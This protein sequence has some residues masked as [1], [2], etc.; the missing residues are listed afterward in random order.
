METQAKKL[1]KTMGW[2]AIA[3][4]GL[5]CTLPIIGT[6]VGVGT[7]TIL[8]AYFEKIAVVVLGISAIL[9]LSLWF[10][11]KTKNKSCETACATDCGCKTELEK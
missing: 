10:S 8:G 1:N 4:C 7:L 2:L 11:K 3:A 6:A 9:L 5:C